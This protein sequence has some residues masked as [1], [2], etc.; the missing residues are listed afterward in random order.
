MARKST[1]APVYRRK[2][3]PYWYTWVYA[4][5]RRV[6]MSTQC[7]DRRAALARAAELQRDYVQPGRAHRSETVA[8]AL[9]AYVEAS[10]GKAPRTVAS[11]QGRAVALA[12]HIGE[13]RLADL[14]R[15]HVQ[16]YV[17]ARG[18]GRR[19]IEFELELLR[20]AIRL[21]KQRGRA[22][23]DVDLLAVV[24]PGVITRKERWL[25]PT[26]ALALLGSLPR[27]RADWVRVA[28]WTGARYAEV[29]SLQ[30]TDVDIGLSWIRIRGTKGRRRD[31][32]ASDRTV[33]IV[34]AFR[35]WLEARANKAG[36]LVQRWAGPRQML[37]GHCARVGIPPCS[38]HDFRRTFAS[39]LKQ[40]GVD[41]MA[42]AKLL[43]HT[44]SKLVDTVYGH[45]DMRALEGAVLHMPETIL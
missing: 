20:S 4:G 21:A 28:L 37:H 30:W 8:D 35:A 25:K 43:G 18:R 1:D 2:G 33:P 27:H 17:T 12:R 45:L 13:V 7:T 9:H 19:T 32:N 44:T 42:V 34:P 36:K 26:E 6:R 40:A 16:R 41:S 23:P 22:V 39:W 10:A 3:S 14:S 29:E 31:Q 24:A 38:P 11:Y 15:D 5:G